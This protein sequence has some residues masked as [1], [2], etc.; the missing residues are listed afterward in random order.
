MDDVEFR[1]RADQAIESL[2]RSLL[3]AEESQT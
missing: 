1:R 2:K 3:H